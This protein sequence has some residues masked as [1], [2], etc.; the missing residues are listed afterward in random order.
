MEHSSTD[1]LWIIITGA[2]V[3]SMQAG[4]AMVESGLTRSKNSINV[5]IKNLTD[6]GISLALFWLIGFALMFGPSFAGLWGY[7]GFAP[8]LDDPWKAGFFFF[9][10]MFC[11]TSATIVSGAVAER[12]RFSSYL[13]GTMVLSGL[14]YPLF[15]HWAWGGALGGVKG[16]LAAKGFV[17][18]AGSTVV[19]SLGAW[20]ALAALLVLGPRLGRFAPDGSVKPINGS[21]IPQAVLGVMLLWFGW[22]GFNGGSTLSLTPAVAGIILRTMLAGAAGMLATLT[23]GWM[24][25]KKPEVSLVLNGS[26]AG[27][28]AV[29]AGAHVLDER[30]SVLVGAVGGLVMLG[31]ASFLRRLRI[32]DAVD[33]IPV[34]LFAGI[35][36]TLA[37]GLFGNIETLGTGLSRISQILVQLEGITVAGL[38]V[39]P[40][41]LAFFTFFNQLSPIRVNRDD[42]SAGLNMAEHGVSTEINDLFTTM[43]RQAKSGDLTLRAPVEPFTEAGQIAGM[44]NAVLD[45]LQDSTVEK[46]EYLNILHNISD[47]LFLLDRDRHLGRYHSKSLHKLFNREQLSGISLDEAIASFMDGKTRTLMHEFLDVAFDATIPWRQVERINPLKE[48]RLHFDDRNGTFTERVYEFQFTRIENQ[49]GSVEQLMVVVRD[50]TDRIHLEEQLEKDRE[51]NRREM[52]LLQM[53]LHIDPETLWTFIGS[54]KENIEKINDELRNPRADARERLELIYCYSHSI[55]GDAEIIGLEHLA[56]KAEALEQLI[57][58]LEKA[59]TLNPEDFLPLVL[60]CSEVL[61]MVTAIENMIQKWQSHSSVL[62]KDISQSSSK[63]SSSLAELSRMAE[64]LASRYEK[65][66]ELRY[67]SFHA[68]MLHNPRGKKILDILVQFIR[69]SVYHGLESPEEREKRGK[70]RKGSIVLTSKQLPGKTRLIYRDDGRGLHPE[71]IAAAALK[72]GL[73]SAAEAERIGPREAAQLIFRPGFSSAQSPDR[74]AGKGVGMTLVRR[75]IVELGAALRISTMPGKYLEFTIDIPE[76]QEALDA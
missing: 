24:I 52:E 1:L 70:P 39:F 14:L 50:L 13:I 7:S 35:W 34:H 23:V 18:F 54:A 33:A 69:N 58:G 22:I 72:K 27:L 71:T 30:T 26:L 65:E 37:V 6:F 73:I 53:I 46:G 31:S 32:D 41:S 4:F 67:D 19:H 76:E 75:R 51:A 17:D 61:E 25:Y 16:W 60:A 11:S 64:R 45:K 68:E 2:L 15:G 38:A 28:V 8:N 44:Y 62:R 42:E 12:M 43:D 20:V 21:S 29:T 48:V 9:Q 3:F 59:D 40:L 74:V 36:G 47:G 66:V 63:H 57:P 56:Q 5:A 49:D 55:K 10:A